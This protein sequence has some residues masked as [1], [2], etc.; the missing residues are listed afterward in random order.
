MSN[1]DV[2]VQISTEVK[3]CDCCGKN[4]LLRTLEVC[5]EDD[6]I[7]YLGVTCAGKRFGLNL[8]GNPY[9]SA[10]RLELYIKRLT[11][12]NMSDIIENIKI[13]ASMW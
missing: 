3:V 5:M 11:E 8:S 10:E 2:S 6:S 1:S 12:D 13:D 4:N 7:I 9:K